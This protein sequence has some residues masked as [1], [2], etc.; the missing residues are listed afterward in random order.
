MNK[1]WNKIGL[2]LGAA[3]GA[4]GAAYYLLMRRPLPQK[5]GRQKLPGLQD[6]VEIRQDRWGVPHIY[7]QSIH[8][9]MFAQG[10]T[11]AQDRLWQMDFQR[12]LVAGR[13]SEILGAVALPLDRWMRILGLQR[14]AE[15]EPAL[16]E[17]G[18]LAALKAYAAGVNAR[19][20]QGKLP[21]EFNLLTY[22]P[23]PWTVGDS[24]CWGKMLAWNLSVNWEAELLRSQLIDRLGTELA[25]ELEPGYLPEWPSILPNGI[26]W[27]AT[28]AAIEAAQRFSGPNALDGVG[29][30][31]WVIAGSRTSS[32]LP[33]LANDMHLGLSIP[34]IW[35]E[36]HLA[37]PEMNITGITF[38]GIPGIIAGHNGQVAWGFTNGFTDVQDLFIERLQRSQDGRVQY[39]YQGKWLPAETRQE[40]IR[41][42]GGKVATQEVITTRHGPIINALA[43]DFSGQSP[44]ALRWTAL[45]PDRM[46][47]ALYHMF[48]TH[49]VHEF[50]HALRQWM[51]PIQNTVFA[52]TKGN[53]AYALPGKV[54]VRAR[55][56]G[57]LPVP[58][59]DGEYEWTGYIPF[60]ELPHL[61]N[62]KEGYIAS[63]N[64]RVA[65]K[66]YPH[67]LGDDHI[68]GNRAARIVE[69]IEA[70]NPIDIK[71]IQQ[72]HLDQVSL[73]ARNFIACLD[74]IN[75]SDPELQIA[76]DHLRAW[77]G[78]LD[79]DSSAAAIYEVLAQRLIYRLLEPH[80][81]ADLTRRYAGKGPT[82]QLAEGSIFGEF[83][84]QWLLHI[85]RQ[86]D[87]HWFD[88]GN[89]EK[90]DD[91]LQIVL[92]ESV[93]LLKTTLGPGIQ[94]WKWGRL[95][96]L[97]LNH[98]L[99][100]IKPLDRLFNRGP[101]PLGGDG[102]T[103]WSSSSARYHLS[104]R[105]IVG[106]AFRFIAD[107]SDLDNCQG[108]LVPGQ[109][110]HPA[111]PH[112]A[113]NIQPWLRGEYHPMA[114]TRKRVEAVTVHVLH[115]QPARQTDAAN[116]KSPAAIAPRQKPEA[117][118]NNDR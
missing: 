56:K 3:A 99:G 19:I 104:S 8:D 17:T 80:L 81:G 85:L 28:M 94:D 6:S 110:G 39:Q 95:H 34:A 7:A 78:T 115:L 111:S 18:T 63:A 33:L 13:L 88:L 36:N 14:V 72:M 101:F 37:C 38:P 60:E 29:S 92:R 109:S 100:A 30:N 20:A 42:K 43:D 27:K 47:D 108:I 86:P 116:T 58:G 9:L 46:F 26:D 62:P 16:L 117:G 55:G 59:W 41:I 54:P 69:L 90:R 51:A 52:D 102:D 68:G 10:Y 89:G 23:E 96:T 35:Y 45:E 21:L 74:T 73:A 5:K 53:I 64:N 83:S 98:T 113:D 107:L 66:S 114:Y 97:T 31:N 106:P 11:H 75:A 103:I 61:L 93:D 84:R 40:Q 1:Q 48:F 50:R 24:I 87:S 15:Q 105:T 49:D 65:D 44:L 77:D 76:L 32:G 57:R 70:H 79:A 118:Q 112:Y 25:A 71:T 2:A 82:P 12:R 22:R 4:A 67:Y 91:V